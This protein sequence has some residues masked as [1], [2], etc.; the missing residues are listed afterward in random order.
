M[1]RRPPHC[2]TGLAL[3]DSLAIDPHKWLYV[4]LEAAITFVRD[5]QALVN[6][7][8]FR[9]SYYALKDGSN[10]TGSDYYERGLQNSRGFRALKVWLGLRQAGKEGFIESIRSNIALAEHL[11]ELAAAHPELE[12]CTRNLSLTT[13]RYVPKDLTSGSA[14][15]EQYL[16][17]LNQKLLLVLQKGGEL[18]VSN[19]VVGG[20]YLLRAC[21]VNFRTSTDDINAL[22][23]IVVREGRA[24]DASIRPDGL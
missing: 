24:I 23:E 16:D 1:V 14:P 15:V 13:F 4:P 10:D 5:P 11:H 2:L 17:E 9:P 7:F 18:F 8:S 6:A 12:A 21:I 22:P 3:A 19:A 20:K